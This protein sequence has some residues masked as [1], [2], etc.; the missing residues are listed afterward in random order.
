VFILLHP[1]LLHGDDDDVGVAN[2]EEIAELFAWLGARVLMAP[3]GE[4]GLGAERVD[5]RL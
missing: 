2:D 4:E 5:E 3:Q 1:D